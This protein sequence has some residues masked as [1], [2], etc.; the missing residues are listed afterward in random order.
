[1]LSPLIFPPSFFI[2]VTFPPF[3]PP[4]SARLVFYYRGVISPGRFM[5]S[6]RLGTFNFSSF[7]DKTGLFPSSFFCLR[8]DSN[9]PSFGRLLLPNVQGRSV[10]LLC[11]FLILPVQLLWLGST[12]NLLILQESGSTIFC[13]L[14]NLACEVHVF[15]SLSPFPPLAQ[16]ACFK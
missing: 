10:Y 5:A 11:R 6:G 12:P 1:M 7:A 8:F 13:P 4:Y 15:S 14:D 2:L 3:F 16:T 9:F